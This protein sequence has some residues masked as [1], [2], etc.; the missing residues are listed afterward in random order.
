MVDC[1]YFPSPPLATRAEAISKWCATSVV[2]S[3]RPQGVRTD[4]LLVGPRF[5]TPYVGDLGVRGFAHVLAGVARTTGGE[6]PQTKP[7]FLVGGGLDVFIFWRLQID[8]LRVNLNRLPKNRSDS[9]PL[10]ALHANVRLGASRCRRP[11]KRLL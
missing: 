2:H 6:S 8:Y 5:T 7:E 3:Q 9:T 11:Q 1:H 4:H 10:C